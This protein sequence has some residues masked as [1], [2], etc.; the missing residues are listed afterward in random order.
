MS[1]ETTTAVSDTEAPT[2]QDTDSNTTVDSPQQDEA[3]AVDSSTDETGSGDEIEAVEPGQPAD[4]DSNGDEDAA[5]LDTSRDP[6]DLVSEMQARDGDS[7]PMPYRNDSAGADVAMGELADDEA[8]EDDPILEEVINSRAE[9]E[10]EE[11]DDEEDEDED[12]EDEEDEGEDEEDEEDED[13][14]DE[15]EDEEDE[16]ED[17]DED[18]EDTAE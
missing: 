13:E 4:Q 2:E 10:D 5:L 7:P 11:E 3:D 15:D 1:H 16:D 18:E 12:E 9:D 8:G 6:A 17:E 14:E